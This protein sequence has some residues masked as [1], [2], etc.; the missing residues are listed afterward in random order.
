MSLQCLILFD[1]NIH[2]VYYSGQL[3][4]GTVLLTLPKDQPVRGNIY[5]FFICDKCGLWLFDILLFLYR[6]LHRDNWNGQMQM[7]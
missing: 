6:H 1:E 2:K 5:R 3:V 7:V 4:K